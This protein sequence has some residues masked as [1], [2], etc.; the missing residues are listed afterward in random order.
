MT[1]IANNFEKNTQKM[2]KKSNFFKEKSH[3]FIKKGKI[4]MSF[5]YMALSVFLNRQKAYI[6]LKL[7]SKN[8]E[9]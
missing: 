6:M 3:I 2:T 7:L 5:F 8:F 1:S 9:L 4:K